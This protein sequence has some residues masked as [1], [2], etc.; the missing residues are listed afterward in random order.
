MKRDS[1]LI[2]CLLPPGSFAAL[3]AW[4]KAANAALLGQTINANAYVILYV[5][6]VMIT[7]YHARKP[8]IYAVIHLSGHLDADLLHDLHEHHQH[9]YGDPHYRRLEPVESV[10][11][12]YVAEAS[13]SYR[14]G[15]C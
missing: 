15:H 9:H 14:S 6:S 11:D 13:A 8:L 7:H 3:P 1:E 10:S 4:E 12:G 2:S 5:Q